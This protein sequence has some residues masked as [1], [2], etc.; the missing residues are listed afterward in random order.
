M[1]HHYKEKLADLR[2]CFAEGEYSAEV[3]GSR[4]YV[5]RLEAYEATEN[6]KAD[7][8][9]I[10]ALVEPRAGL[11]VLDYGCGLG[12][13]CAELTAAGSTAHGTDICIEILAAARQL[14]PELSFLAIDQVSGMYDV[15]VSMHVLGHVRDPQS[16]LKRMRDLLRPEGILVMCVPNPAY[17]LG[18]IPNNIVNDYLPDP[19]AIRCW[20]ERRIVSELR[21]AG[22]RPEGME[23]F[24]EFPPLFPIDAMRSRL[25]GKAIKC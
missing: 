18:M 4:D 20:S 17:T 21:A 8:K 14:H 19:T 16:T 10:R 7:R 3:F 22:F 9:R 23:P 5:A 6:C 11:K 15:V 13:L 2:L 25:V 1:K 12:G 24:G